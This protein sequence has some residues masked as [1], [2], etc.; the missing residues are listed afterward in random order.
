MRCFFAFFLAFLFCACAD[1]AS[2]YATLTLRQST[3]ILGAVKDTYQLDDKAYKAKFF[4]AWHFKGRNLDKKAIFWAFDGYLNGQY[5]FFNKQIIPQN[6]FT[7]AISNANTQAFLTLKQKAIITQNSFLKNLP[8]QTAILKDPFKQGEGVPF[9]YALDSVLNFGSPVLISHFTLDKKF[10]FVLSETG[11]GFVLAAHLEPL[12]N[13]QARH[14]EN[15]NFITPLT[16]RLA[17]HNERGDFVFEARI[18]AIYAYDELSNGRYKGQA[19]S[20]SYEISAHNAKPFPL[21]WG[22]F[23]VKA[24]INELLN[25]P[26]GWGGYDFERDCSALTRD[27]FAAF[28]AYLP[29]NSLAQSEF[30]GWTRFD[31]SHLNNEQKLKFIARYAKPYETLLYLKG[32]IMLFVGVTKGKNA[33]FHA[34]WGIR[35][36]NDGRALIAKSALTTLDIGKN[37]SDVAKSDLLLSRLESISI[38]RLS[39]QEWQRIERALSKF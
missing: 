35:T 24:L 15:S 16:E 19:G 11:W 10:A 8:V 30:S 14:Y 38:Y 23:N 31:I 2:P 34:V 7:K 12:S 3:S 25:R 27:F 29:R 20:V 1:K 28:G 26:Y 21:M 37:D 32:H 22:D 6:F 36:K 9:D 5:Y 33:A 13:A 17:V 4:A 18:G 39:P